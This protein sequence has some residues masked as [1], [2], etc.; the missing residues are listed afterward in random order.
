MR[1]LL[2]PRPHELELGHAIDPAGIASLSSG[3]KA[4]R[5]SRATRRPFGMEQLT[6]CRHNL[7]EIAQRTDP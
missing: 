1:V 7:L 2:P 4:R 3:E 6:S 5:T